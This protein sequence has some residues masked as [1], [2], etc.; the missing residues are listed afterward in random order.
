MN[1]HKSDRRRGVRGSGDIHES[2][3]EKQ[4]ATHIGF[5]KFVWGSRKQAANVAAH[6]V[7][8]EAAK[9]A[10]SDP[11]RVFASDKKHS[12][13]ETPF[14]CFGMVKGRVLTVRFVLRGCDIRIIGAGYWRDGKEI[15]EN[16]NR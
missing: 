3:D 6:G 10:F 4:Y 15:Y 14:F 1:G 12:R 2:I 16:Q 5:V 9:L 8:F 7:N 13:A 11:K